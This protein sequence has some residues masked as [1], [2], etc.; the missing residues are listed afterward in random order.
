MTTT[1]VPATPSPVPAA[2]HNRLLWQ[3]GWPWLVVVTLARA[4]LIF[5]VTLAA[6]A[7][8]PAFGSW[9]S[10][11]VKTGSMAP[12]VQPGD[13]VVT[14]PLGAT[15]KMPMGRVIAF[16]S[17]SRTDG[18]GNPEI[19]VHRL[20]A[21]TV[22]GAYQ[23]AGD[24]NADVDSDPVIRSQIVGQARLLVPYVGL[25]FVWLS[26]H[27]WLPLILWAALTLLAL[28]ITAANPL[29][30]LFDQ[31]D[32]GGVGPDTGDDTTPVDALSGAETGDG[33][34]PPSGALSIASARVIHSRRWALVWSFILALAIVFAG[35]YSLHLAS[36]KFSAK[37]ANA[38]NSWAFQTY[39]SLTSA[40]F[41][42]I[43]STASAVWTGNTVK[44]TNVATVL[45][46][47]YPL[48]NLTFSATGSLGSSG[49]SAGWGVWVRASVASNL[50]SGYC[51]TIDASNQ[52]FYLR[53]W[54]AGHELTSNLASV[55]FPSG[56]TGSASHVVVLK[57][58][59]NT[60]LASVDGTQYMSVTLPTANVVNNGTTYIVPTGSQYGLRTWG[61]TVA[62]IGTLTVAAL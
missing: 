31:Q 12:R 3:R 1:A 34:E 17:V 62:T 2:T 8:V 39:K 61:Q 20:V 9:N 45:S 41:I 16:K 30:R 19:I 26:S 4:Y 35:S 32:G 23:T 49:N 56:F 46:N 11:V 10:Y 59:G 57:V 29:G 60:L 14:A 48:S 13:V 36:G 15:E 44:M 52:R 43:P 25:P 53:W 42:T 22:N 18:N 50:M 33:D 28:A 27:S 58:T 5:F 38:K 40:D 6:I 7:I 21:V 55:K 47:N 54:S 37:S 51:F 24:A